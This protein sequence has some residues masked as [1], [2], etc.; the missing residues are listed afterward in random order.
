MNGSLGAHE[1]EGE[2]VRT[3]M[4]TFGNLAGT[5]AHQASWWNRK[6]RTMRTRVVRPHGQIG[7]VRVVLGSCSAESIS[8]GGGRRVGMGG[9]AFSLHTY[10]IVA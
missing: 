5:C 7:R 4:D 3:H 6:A 2:S 9:V 1:W 10:H 8:E